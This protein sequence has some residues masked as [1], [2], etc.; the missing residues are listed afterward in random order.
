ML[1]SNGNSLLGQQTSN[2]NCTTGAPSQTST[3]LFG[4]SRSAT[5]A[6][7]PRPEPAASTPVASVSTAQ[8]QASVNP[9]VP[10]V[11]FPNA[12]ASQ[13]QASINPP[14]A[15]APVAVPPPAQ[16]QL[17]LFD[18]QRGRGNSRNRRGGRNSGH[19][20]GN[21]T[22]NS[23]YQPAPA[24]PAPAPVQAPVPAPTATSAPAHS[25]G[26]G[27]GGSYGGFGQEA[28][29]APVPTQAPVPATPARLPKRKPDFVLHAK[30]YALGEKYEI[31]D[32]KALALQK[33]AFEATACW[34]FSSFR[35]GAKEAYTSTVDED[36]GMRDIVV[37]TV[38]KHRLLISMPDFKNVLKE[39][40]LGYDLLMRLRLAEVTPLFKFE[41]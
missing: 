12:F 39:T 41:D 31:K 25:T 33:F 29:P 17:F 8:P 24:T 38:L 22:P 23:Y 40:D 4:P 5:S 32:L 1:G 7:A 15:S 9:P 13:A 10:A 37:E 18:N 27:S 3:S 26:F 16:P 2:E 11:L 30:I 21:H 36:R 20:R 34:S 28:T 35:I 6:F 14:A 19:Q